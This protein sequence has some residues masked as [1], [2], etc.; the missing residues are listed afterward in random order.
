MTQEDDLRRIADSVDEIAKQQR[1]IGDIL[2]SILITQARSQENFDLHSLEQ[3]QPY[4]TIPNEE[5]DG[6]EAQDVE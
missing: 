2:E 5:V 1:K 6:S 3:I 4:W